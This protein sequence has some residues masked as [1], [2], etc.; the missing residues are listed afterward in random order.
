[1]GNPVY[2]GNLAD[3]PAPA[4]L[5]YYPGDVI[6]NP[7]I[8]DLSQAGRYPG[9]AGGYQPYPG[10]AG[11]QNSKRKAGIFGQPSLDQFPFRN[12]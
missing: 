11:A 7:Y 5:P 10:D 9:A 1:M 6:L 3:N 2:I 8:G 4:N 12:T